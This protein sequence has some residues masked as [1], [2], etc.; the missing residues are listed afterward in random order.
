MPTDK[1]RFERFRLKFSIGHRRRPGV[2]MNRNVHAPAGRSIIPRI[3]LAL[4]QDAGRPLEGE[5][6]VHTQDPP[7]RFRS[8][9]LSDTHLG[10]KGCRA[11]RLFD[12]LTWHDAD[13]IYLVGDIFHSLRPRRSNWSPVHD[14]VVQ[15]LMNKA[16]VGRRI[17]Y[18]PGNHD[19]VFRSHYGV[20]LNGIEVVEQALHTAADGKRYL[21]MHGDCFDM[22]VRHAPWLSTIGGHIGDALRSCGRLLNRVGRAS[23]LADWSL[24][25]A[26]LSGVNR[27]I[28]RG[29]RFEQRLTAE[30]REQGATGVICGHFH[31]ATIHEQFGVIYANCGDW[32]ESCTAIAEEADGRLQVIRWKNP[33]TSLQSEEFLSDVEAASTPA[34]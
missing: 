4:P 1:S 21:V 22:V 30:A 24:S 32:I 5:A 19:E 3:T 23:G 2:F 10:A 18:I 28:T 25:E 15:N 11:D 6:Q 14:A 27:V 34:T 13:V 17:V 9:F 16:H 8:L 7:R 31:S 26:V 12:F 20:Y 29:H 33:Q